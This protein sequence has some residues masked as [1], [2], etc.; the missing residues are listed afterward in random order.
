[1][2]VGEL[3]A[4]PPNIH[5]LS[6]GSEMRKYVKLSKITAIALVVGLLAVTGASAETPPTLYTAIQV[7]NLSDTTNA[8]IQIDYYNQNGSKASVGVGDTLT[9][10]QFKSYDA[11]QNVPSDLP[12]SWRGAAV[13]SSDQ[14]VGAIVGMGNT[15]GGTY[16][17]E[18]YRGFPS[19]ETANSMRLPIILKNI[20]DKGLTFYTEFSVQNAGSGSTSGTVTF[21]PLSGGSPIVENFGPLLPGAAQPF[22]QKADTNLGTAFIG[23]AQVDVTSGG[24]IA[25]TVLQK[26]EKSGPG[27][28]LQLYTGFSGGSDVVRAPLLL[29]GVANQGYIYSTAI[30]AMNI[31]TTTVTAHIV[32][33]PAG[34]GAALTGPDVTIAPGKLSSF[35][36]SQDGS[37]PNVWVGSGEVVRVSG[38][39]NALIGIVGQGGTFNGSYSRAF[40]FPGFKATDG[41]LKWKAPLVL[42]QIVDGPN[43]WSTAIQ[44]MDVSGSSNNVRITY[45]RTGQADITFSRLVGANQLASFDPLQSG[46][47]GLDGVSNF[48]GSAII[49]SL[50]SKNIVAY[51]GQGA[52]NAGDAAEAY[53]P[54]K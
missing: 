18:A 20:A 30:Q 24:P 48:I 14:L 36:Q 12:A 44:V 35:D 17:A 45:K 52:V 2:R 16:V 42:K 7:M 50:D 25:V 33:H 31:A 26:G 54:F 3:F 41:A 38:P 9:P 6:G 53:V 27:R 5:T 51:V 13:I 40:Y 28:T 37:L 8:S 4:E 1:M 29:K 22:D 15:D 43:N 32:Y 21:F 19:A 49:E 10:N 39:N 11:S 46:V 47:S 34:G 23:S